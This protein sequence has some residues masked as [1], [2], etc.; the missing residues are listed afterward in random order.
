[1]L[2]SRKSNSLPLKKHNNKKKEQKQNKTNQRED[3]PETKQNKYENKKIKLDFFKKRCFYFRWLEV[4]LS[5]R[6]IS[7][8]YGLRSLKWEEDSISYANTT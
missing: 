1:M 6:N 4:S 3:V 2:I 8:E 7:H 5:A